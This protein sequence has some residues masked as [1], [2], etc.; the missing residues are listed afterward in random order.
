M[1][2]TIRFLFFL[3]ILSFFFGFYTKDIVENYVYGEK[4]I[5]FTVLFSVI[6]FLPLF[7]FYRWKG[8]N[9]KDY[10]LTKENYDVIKTTKKKKK[11]Q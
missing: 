6:I 7:L 8:K 2:L 5:G 11:V 4:I 9:I 3:I 1:K 10:T